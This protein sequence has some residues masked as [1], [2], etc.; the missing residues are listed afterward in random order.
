MPYMHL[1][2]DRLE[3]SGAE[4]G[5]FGRKET[6]IPA[7]L[8]VRIYGM[9]AAG[10]PFGANVVT[11]NVSKGGALLANVN[12]PLDLGDMIGLQ[13]GVT[14]AKFRVVRLGKKGTMS[15]GQVGVKCLEPGKNIF[16]LEEDK[17]VSDLQEME[18]VQRR[19]VDGKGHGERR[20]AVRHECDI[21][22]HLTV[23]DTEINLWSR[24]TDISEGGCYVE[25]RSPFN[26][27]TRLNITLFLEPEHLVLPAVVRTSFAGMG[28][29]LQFLFATPEQKEQLIGFLQVQFGGH[30]K[31]KSI[32]A[33]ETPVVVAM[34]A[35]RN[36]FPE[37]ERLQRLLAETLG[38]AERVKLSPRES[39]QME[40]LAQSFRRQLQGLKAEVEEKQKH[41]GAA[42]S[43]SHSA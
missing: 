32:A 35:A 37:L 5:D 34:P 28:C 18:A 22:A 27:G 39:E 38:W 4:P 16:G 8:P 3:A 2:E 12:V 31:P 29:G 24:C 14:R 25:S 19:N 13:R 30:E 26:V 21:G 11:L 20:A 15:Q 33:V 42:F 40:E 1:A 36:A 9:D 17:P 23:V 43:E 41:S 7:V 6:R 10:K